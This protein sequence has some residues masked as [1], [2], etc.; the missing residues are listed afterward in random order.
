MMPKPYAS[1]I[2]SAPV[3][4]VWAVVRDFNGLPGWHPAVA[5]SELSGDA[6]DHIGVSRNLVLADG[7][8]IVEKL[9]AADDAARSYTY[10]IV[11][12]P[13]AVRRYRATIRFTPVTATGQTFGEWW[14]EYDAE[15]ADEPNLT[16]TFADDVFAVGLAALV[17]R[18]E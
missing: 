10:D 5:S 18:F 11:E 12:S 3:D 8:R 15:A 17:R 4:E 6:G 16:K 1:A 13:F 14:T 7:G 2:I 9:I